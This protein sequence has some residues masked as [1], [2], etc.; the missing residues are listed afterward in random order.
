MQ[1][2]AR[3]KGIATNKSWC[4]P[5]MPSP[6]SRGTLTCRL[7]PCCV[8]ARQEESR[9]RSVKLV[10]RSLVNKLPTAGAAVLL[11]FLHFIW[12]RSPRVPRTFPSWNSCPGTA[13]AQ[14]HRDAARVPPRFAPKRPSRGHGAAED[15]TPCRH[16]SR[17]GGRP[18]NWPSAC[19][20]NKSASGTKRRPAAPRSRQ[21]S[22]PH[23]TR[24]WPLHRDAHQ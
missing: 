2:G 22:I 21:H 12:R 9:R 4:Q 6:R 23:R 11:R 19:S 1:D 24:S 15:T 3:R 13:R 5:W 18:V 20:W 8:R 7:S 14:C 10:S 17:R 16:R